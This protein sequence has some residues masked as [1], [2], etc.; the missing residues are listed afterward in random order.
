MKRGVRWLA[1]T[2]FAIIL[3]LVLSL[4]AL[5]GT[6]GE[7]RAIYSSPPFLLLLGAL[8]MA[9]A[10]CTVGK[11]RRL[12]LPVLVI[13]AAVVLVLAGAVIS[14][15]GYVS[16]VNVH[17]GR[18]TGAAYRWDVNKELPLG[19]DLAVR[20]VNS[21]YYPV[22]VQVGVL[23]GSEKVALFTVRTGESF[24]FD[25]FT[26]TANE[27]HLQGKRL[28]L[29][30]AEKGTELGKIDTADEGTIASSFPYRFRLVAYRTPALKR[31]W[32]D[33]AL[34]RE[35]RVLAEG[36]SEVNAPFSWQGLQFFHVQS[37][38][39]QEGIYAGIQI[40]RDPGKPLVFAGLALL[41]VGAVLLLVRRCYGKR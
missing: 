35:S 25:R 10:V 40:V 24:R 33:L 5:P 15:R 2:E 38:R 21:E 37:D 34:L 28:S 17:E 32:V 8:G 27:L 6:F 31:T 20:K 26:V 19:F 4:L 9:T 14:A 3:F 1:S 13:H 18:S 16:T 22:P 7:S 23:R 30:V 11:G 36:T 39:D 41:G 29:S 12:P